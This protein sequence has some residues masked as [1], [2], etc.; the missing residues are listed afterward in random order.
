MWSNTLIFPTAEDVKQYSYRY[1]GYLWD[2]QRWLYGISEEQ[3]YDPDIY[4]AHYEAHNAAVIDYFRWLPDKLLILN[5][6][7]DQA[8]W[9]LAQFLGKTVS[10][11]A[12]FPWENKT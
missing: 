12:Q 9:K 4:K 2:C 10:K 1:Q 8:Y 7:E 11:D 5:I 6:T 3:A